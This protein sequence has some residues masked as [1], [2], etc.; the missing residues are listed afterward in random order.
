MYAKLAEGDPLS[1]PLSLL[2]TDI[3]KE[4]LTNYIRLIPKDHCEAWP[5]QMH[6][7]EEATLGPRFSWINS[8]NSEIVGLVFYSID[9]DSTKYKRAIIHHLSS[10]TMSTFSKMLQFVLSE[11]SKEF[12]GIRAN[13]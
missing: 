12:R 5:S 10:I 9:V 1:E 6:T 3:S 7:L 2:E 13:I 4:D 11:L 8:S